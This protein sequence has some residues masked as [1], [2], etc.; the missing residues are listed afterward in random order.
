MLKLGRKRYE[1]L[2]SVCTEVLI[3]EGDIIVVVA[4]VVVAVVDVDVAVVVDVVVVVDVAVVA[5]VAIKFQ[6]G[7]V[8]IE[9][10]FCI[11]Q[12]HFEQ[13]APRSD[14]KQDPNE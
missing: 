11:S 2:Q 5:S 10:V 13:L 1:Q 14:E 8:K 7:G 9:F 6:K 3:Q 4:V 12:F